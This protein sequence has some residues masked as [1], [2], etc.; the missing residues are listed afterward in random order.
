MSFFRN[1]VSLISANI[2][3]V[4]MALSGATTYAQ[5][6]TPPAASASS[7]PDV[8]ASG[9]AGQI[10]RAEVERMADEVVPP[11]DLARFWLSPDAV[12]RMAR[13]LYARRV[14]AEQALRDGIDKTPETAAQL[15][16][17]RE[18]VLSEQLLKKKVE[19]VTPDQAAIARLAR[20]EYQAQPERFV[21]SEEVR[22]RHILLTMAPDGS[23]EAAVKA[24]AIALIKQLRAGA[25]FAQLAKGRSADRGSA[26]RGGDLGYFPKG[27]MA[28][29]FEA[30]AFALK[31]PGDVSEPIKT[32]FGYH[33]IELSERKPSTRETFEQAL[34]ELQAEIA[35]KL[36]AQERRYAWEKAEAGVQIDEAAIK[37]WLQA[38]PKTQ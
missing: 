36:S 24:D 4:A 7:L 27:K 19:A 29:E 34:P 15:Q 12:A 17:M 35:K 38:R 6:A 5:P 2:V 22:V 33:I 32:S 13:S 25:D 11:A 18:Q 1:S 9:P 26:Q 8:L 30:A 28:P 23:N 37:D 16:S 10:T 14:L 31:K 20:S 21:K 3:G